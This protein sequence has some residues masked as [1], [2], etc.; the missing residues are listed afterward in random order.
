MSLSFDCIFELGKIFLNVCL[1]FSFPGSRFGTSSFVKADQTAEVSQTVAEDRQVFAIR[2]HDSHTFDAPIH[3][4][5]TLVCV[6]MVC[7]RRKRTPRKRKR[8]GSR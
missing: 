3:I 6:H 7:D 5:C 4:S 8:L 1:N 2:R